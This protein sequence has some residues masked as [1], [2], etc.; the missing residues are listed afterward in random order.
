MRKAI[1]YTWLLALLLCPIVLWILPADYFSNHEFVTCPSHAFFAIECFGCG[2]TRA[3]MN[4]HNFQ[5]TEAIFYNALV[6]AVYPFLVWLWQKWV[7]A[8]LRF[9]NLYPRQ[10]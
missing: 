10:Q 4:F 6:I 1:H 2:I 5:F 8:E 7:R 3:V 9:L